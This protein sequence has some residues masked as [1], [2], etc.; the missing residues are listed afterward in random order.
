MQKEGSVACQFICNERRCINC[1]ACMDVCPVRCL[2]LT[3]PT[4]SSVELS[5]QAN[6]WMIEFSIQTAKCTGCDVCFVE[7]PTEAI[8]NR[9]QF[10]GNLRVLLHDPSGYEGN[11]GRGGSAVKKPPAKIAAVL[12]L[13][14][15]A[16]VFLPSFG[17][18]AHAGESLVPES[19]RMENPGP[20]A[21]NVA[22][23]M[24]EEWVQTF[25]SDAERQAGQVLALA[26]ANLR[27][28]GLDLRLSSLIT[29][30]SADDAATIH[31]LLDTLEATI[32]GGEPGLIVGLTADSYEGTVDGLAHARSP[33]LLI[34]HHPGSLERDAYVLTH[35]IGHV[36]GLDH[37]TCEDLL[38]FMADHGYDPDE[39][40][41]DEHQELLRENVGYF[42]YVRYTSGRG[43]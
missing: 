18:R 20:Y 35:E 10:A 42:G 15:L 1:G 34:R 17:E 32:S 19:W 8:T 7:C 21:I 39:H 23:A 5:G 33:Y 24:D 26:A 36:F 12:I 27:P 38:C 28:A 31:P 3:R 13:L 25:G 43:G 14:I 29:W 4:R 40:W 37:H 16:G 9:V 2:N 11:A 41:C 30:A 6:E 22:L